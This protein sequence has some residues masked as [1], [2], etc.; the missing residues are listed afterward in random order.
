M[1]VLDQIRNIWLE[2]VYLLGHGAHLSEGWRRPAVR[3]H[4]VR[5]AELGEATAG[6]L[7]DE[8]PQRGE[9][10]L[11]E[12]GELLLSWEQQ[13]VQPRQDPPPGLLLPARPV[14]PNN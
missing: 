2:A 11:P 13:Y 8:R 1:F 14:G 3:N 4:N 7:S 5:A 9:D 12:L 6:A 10:R